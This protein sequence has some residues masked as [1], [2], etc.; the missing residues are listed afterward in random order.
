MADGIACRHCGWQ[1]GDHV[2][3]DT[4]SKAPESRAEFLD[5]LDGSNERFS[6]YRCSLAE[7]DGYVPAED[8]VLAAKLEEENRGLE[9]SVGSPWGR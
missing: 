9:R 3:L 8:P 5:D 7:C 1:Q 2:E 6:E 4:Y